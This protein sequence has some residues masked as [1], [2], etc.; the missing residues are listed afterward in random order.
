MQA[1]G[2][3]PECGLAFD[4]ASVP[5]LPPLPGAGRLTWVALR[6]SVYFCV[7]M[8]GLILLGSKTMGSTALYIACATPPLF[9][10]ATFASIATFIVDHAVPRDRRGAVWYTVLLGAGVA[11]GVGTLTGMLALTLLR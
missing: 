10:G 5:R 9:L 2:L 3:C 11:I 1:P 4:P 7:A 8:T 6:P